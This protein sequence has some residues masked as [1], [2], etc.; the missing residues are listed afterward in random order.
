MNS[1]NAE[2]P[3]RVCSSHSVTLAG[4]RCNIVANVTA[5]GL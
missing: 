4:I 2:R 3:S 5:L 1:E